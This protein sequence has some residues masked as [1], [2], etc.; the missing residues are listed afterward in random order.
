M[1]WFKK[2]VLDN[3]FAHDVGG[4][5]QKPLHSLNPIVDCPY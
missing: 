4:G 1:I 5:W 3:M 2:K